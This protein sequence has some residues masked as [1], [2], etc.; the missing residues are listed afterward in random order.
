MKQKAAELPWPDRNLPWAFDR[1]ILGP[2]RKEE[3]GGNPL[4]REAYAFFERITTKHTRP[5]KDL[6]RGNGLADESSFAWLLMPSL[7]V[8]VNGVKDPG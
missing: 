8:I 4:L 5:T 2:G 7:F 6:A 1:V 3:P